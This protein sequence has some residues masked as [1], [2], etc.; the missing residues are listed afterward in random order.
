MSVAV[1]EQTPQSIVSLR[2]GRRRVLAGW[3]LAAYLLPLAV[4]VLAVRLDGI[5]IPQLAEALA[6]WVSSWPGM[7]E[8]RFGHIEAAANIAVFIPIGF[9]LT[10]ML[11]RRS[12]GHAT[13]IRGTWRLG[14][15]DV[16]V[17]LFCT[18]FS[19][20]IEL[21]QLFLLTERSATLRDLICNSA[22]ALAGVVIFRM[23]D[24][25]RAHRRLNSRKE[26]AS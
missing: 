14:V 17:W 5:G 2:S 18:L 9:L 19:A 3:L 20:A 7:P 23:A 22:G 25:W 24:S 4:L 10:A 11:R 21:V 15:P 12:P 8:V 16:A 26:S 6:A 1:A 13:G